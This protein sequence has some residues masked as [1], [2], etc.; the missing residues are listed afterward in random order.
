[1]DERPFQKFIDL[2]FLHCSICHCY[3]YILSWSFYVLGAGLISIFCRLFKR[4]LAIRI[5]M[6]GCNYFVDYRLDLFGLI[7]G[8]FRLCCELRWRVLRYEEINSFHFLR[9]I[10]RYESERAKYSGK[11][12]DYFAAYFASYLSCFILYKHISHCVAA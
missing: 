4:E 12:K 6:G 9:Q 7:K 3:H 2:K 8:S 1:M 5:L 10:E 11:N